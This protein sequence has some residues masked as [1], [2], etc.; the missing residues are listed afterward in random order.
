MANKY[1][2]RRFVEAASVAFL[3]AELS[4]GGNASV[5]DVV[6]KA[7]ELYDELE[8]QVPNEEKYGD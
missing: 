2:K 5:R 3:H 4:R 6:N 7:I 8:V 1:E